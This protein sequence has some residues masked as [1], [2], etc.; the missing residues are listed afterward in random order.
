M[1]HW[2]NNNYGGK[3]KYSEKKLSQIH[4]THYKFHVDW[5]GIEPG[6]Q[7]RQAATACLSYG[8]TWSLSDTIMSGRGK[9]GDGPSSDKSRYSHTPH[10]DLLVNDR[11]NIWWWSHNIIIFFLEEPSCCVVVL[12]KMLFS[13]D[14]KILSSL[15]SK[16]LKF[17]TANLNNMGSH[18][19]SAEHVTSMNWNVCLMM[20]ACNWMTF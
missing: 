14:I 5:H 9:D 19:V 7:W 15:L 1:E 20:V 8:T 3:P 16:C 11:Q 17:Y 18:T 13:Q 6:P 2:W 10:N 4:F 12:T